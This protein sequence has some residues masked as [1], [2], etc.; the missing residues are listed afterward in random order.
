MKKFR[1]SAMILVS[2]LF[3]AS[4]SNEVRNIPSGYVGKKLTPSGWDK[5]ILEAGQ[6]DIGQK[7]D[8][9][10]STQ[11]VLLE[12]TTK[13]V[14]EQFMKDDPAD[15][16]DHRVKTADQTP[17]TVDIYVQISVPTDAQIRNSV[18]AMITP[19]AT[20]DERVSTISVEDIYTRFA[21]MTIRGKVREI[22]VKYKD[23]EDAMKNFG[24]INAEIAQMI[25]SVVRESKAPFEIVNAQLS[26]IQEDPTILESKTKLIAA[27]NEVAAIEKV[28]D[29]IR[30]N[31]YYLEARRLDV[32]EKIGGK[33]SSNLVIMDTKNPTTLA[34]PAK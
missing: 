2:V 17:L 18:F 27:T 12:T 9:G 10:T 23:N 33:S 1:V 3:L 34:L 4:C 19:T 11:L 26:N 15:K 14:K 7:Q 32:L 22:F 6:S 28:G 16:Q 25:I 31:P 21:R 5:Q 8:D 29:A 13:T 30:K 20:K 24:K